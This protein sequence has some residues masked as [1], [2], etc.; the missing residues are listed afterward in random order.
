MSQNYSIQKVEELAGGDQE[1]IKVLVNT[2]LEEI[3]QDL[4]KLINAAENNNPAMAYQYA[5]KMKPSFQLFNV[6][7]IP[8]IN[9]ME[10]WSK[11]EIDFEK[12]QQVAHFIRENVE[13]VLEELSNDF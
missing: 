4:K 2:F 13:K 6:A 10:G 11:G 8:Q 1:F 12:A 9:E 3:S 7:V 5:H